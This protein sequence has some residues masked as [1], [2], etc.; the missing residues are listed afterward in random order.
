MEQDATS[1]APPG[2]EQAALW[3]RITLLD[4]LAEL[5]RTRP[6]VV[7]VTM[8][9]DRGD[10]A[11]RL[12]Y[13]DLRA[14]AR[15]I[16]RYLTHERGLRA[17][18]TVLL[19]YPPSMDF[20][21]ALVGCMMAGVIPVP[22]APPNPLR[23]EHAHRELAAVAERSGAQAILTNGQYL[24]GIRVGGL[25]GVLSGTHR[26]RPG[27]L[28]W[29]RT[30]RV[31][32]DDI[33]PTHRARPGDVAFLQ[34]TSGS[35]SSPKGVVITHANVVHQLWLNKRELGLGAQ[36]VAVTWV[37]HFHDFGLIS[38]L[39]SAIF[40]NGRLY[41][42]SPL[43]FL[44]KPA[45]WFDV[46]S[47]V[48]ATHTAAPDFAY[49]LAVRRSNDVQRANWDLS[50]LSV[51]MSAAEPVRWRTQDDFSA[52]FRVAGLDATALC[53][54]Y[55]LAEH[56]VGVTVGGRNRLCVERLSLELSGEVKPL[57]PSDDG[58][59]LVGCGPPSQGVDLRIVD[60]ESHTALP[61]GRVGEIWVDSPSK[62]AGY[63]G[64]PDLSA[65]RFHARLPGGA[66]DGYLRTGDL[67]F[68]WQ[69]ELYITGRL[70]DLI[71]LNGRNLHPQDLEETV[72]EVSPLIRKGRV[73][74]FSVPTEGRQVGDAGEGLAVVVEL[75]DK[76]PKPE[77]LDALVEQIRERLLADHR[78]A[79]QVL[80]L[81]RPGVIQKTTS[82]KLRRQA[83]RQ[84]HLDGE[85]AARA[86]RVV[87]LEPVS[88]N[89]AEQ[90]DGESPQVSAPETS[91]PLETWMIREVASAL[92][93]PEAS[94]SPGAS[95]QA[96]GADSLLVVSLSAAI[97][98]RWGVEIG[99]DVVAANPT[100]ADLV[101]TVHTAVQGHADAESFTEVST[102]EREHI[103][104][105]LPLTP[106]QAWVVETVGHRIP[107]HWNLPVIL[108]SDSPVDPTTL[109]AALEQL[110]QRHAALRLR[111]SPAGGDLSAWRQ[112][113]EAVSAPPV[114]V[115]DLVAL[116]DPDINRAVERDV[117]AT[118]STLDLVAGPVWRA[119]VYHTGPGR[120]D[121]LLLLFHHFV[122]DGFSTRL[123]LREF[124][125]LYLAFEAG[126]PTPQRS[127][128]QRYGD[129]VRGLSAEACSPAMRSELAYWRTVLQGTFPELPYDHPQ[130]ENP[131]G[132]ARALSF[133]LAPTSSASL[134]GQI[135]GDPDIGLE[136]IML[137]ALEQTFARWGGMDTPPLIDLQRHGRSFAP[138]GVRAERT[139][140][141]TNDVFPIQLPPSPSGSGRLGTRAIQQR[142]DAV[143]NLGRG[144][145]L[146]RYM[147]TEADRA[148]LDALPVAAV[149]LLCHS[150]LMEGARSE[151]VRFRL[152]DE[153]P[154]LSYGADLR[155]RYALLVYASVH[156][157][158]LR[159]D[160]AYGSGLFEPGTAEAFMTELRAA[161]DRLAG[162][163]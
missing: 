124:E 146:L 88:V 66:P 54:S 95:L 52:A 71:I 30:E 159:V 20:V 7:P 136:A 87:T 158:R 56:T 31:P 72:A 78:V 68:L 60:P 82:G 55:G 143:P 90:I 51:V 36:S 23:P 96:M 161:L 156:G 77:S 33:Q 47:R 5:S 106:A 1:A 69:G 40:G 44:K 65:A 15:G 134:L 74:A 13:P 141:W 39:L 128:P 126:Q 11:T 113:F 132:L 131:E 49:R 125:A 63:W 120:P 112:R 84:A 135:A 129:W 114:R 105:P 162:E 34:Y 32:A 24:M 46:M 75:A 160:L 119:V 163:D 152:S 8:V 28:P 91:L 101:Q 109:R 117:H 2:M 38:G 35:T 155:A 149:K 92:G 127:L 21:T 42:L 110:A 29:W 17:G 97:A 137:H 50:A 122:I 80:V 139:I 14:A 61:E 27:N 26:R 67:G 142:L 104:Q 6:D 4:R 115:V 83:M 79:C 116:R 133:E 100:L 64:E 85:L 108:S 130:D 138:D 98:E 94:V 3:Q 144:Y 81:G 140:A 73:A 76:R 37:P 57:D 93:V 102:A 19:V 41:M 25:R 150:R 16:A 22:V 59:R 99:A 154:G 12:T 18:V 121:R 147:G 45:V 145:G 70:K 107:N 10:D 58:V 89:A 103:D 62:A 123:L 43:A 111:L 118:Q 53:P 9:N 48:R 157:E 151:N 153:S 86:H 148:V